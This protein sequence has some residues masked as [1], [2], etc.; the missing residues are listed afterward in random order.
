MLLV[1]QETLA[2]KEGHVVAM[3][4]FA[5]E[6]VV[7]EA[8]DFLDVTENDVAFT[9]QRLRYILSRQFWNIVLQE[10][11]CQKTH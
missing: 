6:I 8:V 2:H 5:Q 9:T 10:I 7:M 1:P 4:Q 3:L 11:F